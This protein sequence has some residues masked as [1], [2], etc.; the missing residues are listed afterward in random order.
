MKRLTVL[1][2][3]L[4]ASPAHADGWVLNNGGLIS[5][6]ESPRV[7]EALAGCIQASQ[8]YMRAQ[9]PSSY[10]EI[11]WHRREAAIKLEYCMYQK[12]YSWQK[13]GPYGEPLPR[14]VVR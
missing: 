11:D 14:S 6:A 7:I 13:G 10:S 3:L 9:T 5:D 1:L 12:G 2:A 4:A 8:R